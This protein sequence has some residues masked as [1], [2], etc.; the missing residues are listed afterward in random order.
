MSKIDHD[1]LNAKLRGLRDHDYEADREARRKK[2]R[3]ALKR[4]AD[5]IAARAEREKA[6]KSAVAKA[7][8]K[9]A[10]NRKRYGG[11]R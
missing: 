6:A 7:A 10:R 5:K 1:A 2:E 8:N 9:K 11:K 4:W 3:E